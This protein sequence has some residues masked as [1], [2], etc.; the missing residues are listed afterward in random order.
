ML[1][2]T[3]LSISSFRV[4]YLAPNANSQHNPWS[5]SL[6]CEAYLFLSFAKLCALKVRKR[7]RGGSLQCTSERAE[8][9]CYRTPKGPSLLAACNATTITLPPSAELIDLPSA[10]PCTFA[11]DLPT[12]TH[13][14]A[15]TFR[16]ATARRILVPA[17]GLS[18]AL[19]SPLLAPL[20]APNPFLSPSQPSS[21][22]RPIVHFSLPSSLS[23]GLLHEW[24]Y[25]QSPERLTQA[26]ETSASGHPVK[27]AA[28]LH[29]LWAN[30]T[31]LQMDDEVLWTAMD[32]EWESV[33]KQLGSV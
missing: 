13:L 22:H 8:L 12:P 9:T 5:S 27:K 32:A 6:S 17:H 33:L 10:L 25:L 4:A 23:Y 24:I 29:G 20:S 18:L 30:V 21:F 7:P 31:A 2:A 3:S 1:A 11:A 19:A 16:D 14:L 26:L 15:I 28:L